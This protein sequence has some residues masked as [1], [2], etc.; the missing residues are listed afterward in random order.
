MFL[1]AYFCVEFQTFLMLLHSFFFSVSF[2]LGFFLC[3]FFVVLGS[4]Q[5]QKYFRNVRQICKAVR[6][7]QTLRERE[8][9]V[10]KRERKPE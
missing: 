5:K 1:V 8:R 9:E 7:W 6:E 10:G 3:G 4:E 2:G